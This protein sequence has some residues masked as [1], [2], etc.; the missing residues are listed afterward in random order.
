MNF[1]QAIEALKYGERVTR[2][3][4]ND[5][6]TFLYYVP[7]G[8]FNPRMGIEANLVNGFGYGTVEYKG[9]IAMKTAQSKAILWLASQT[10]ML[11]EDWAIVHQTQHC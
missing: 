8:E 9:Y 3:G 10:D 11:A 2:L 1:G 7:G 4:W 5:K 6:G